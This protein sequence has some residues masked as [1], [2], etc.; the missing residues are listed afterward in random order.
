MGLEFVLNNK[1]GVLEMET[2]LADGASRISKS[3]SK[4][5][6]LLVSVIRLRFKL[7]GA[8]RVE[9]IAL[10]SHLGQDL[11]VAPTASQDWIRQSIQASIKTVCSVSDI[12]GRLDFIRSIRRCPR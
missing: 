10:A 2:E 1:V 4:L 6:E 8:E 3:E 5:S 9:S 12:W 11:T 7:E